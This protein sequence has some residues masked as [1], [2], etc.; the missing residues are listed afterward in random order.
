MCRPAGAGPGDPPIPVRNQVPQ[1]DA[2]V[3]EL[4]QAIVEI[5]EALLPAS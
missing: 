3:R 4:P 5:D 1:L 2:K